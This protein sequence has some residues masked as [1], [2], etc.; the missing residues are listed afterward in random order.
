[1]VKC[2][3]FSLDEMKKGF[4]YDSKRKTREREGGKEWTGEEIEL[5]LLCK[6]RRFV[7]SGKTFCDLIQGWAKL[8]RA[9]S[10]R[11]TNSSAM[12]CVFRWLCLILTR[13]PIS[14]RKLSSTKPG[15]QE[16]AFEYKAHNI[17]KSTFPDCN[18]SVPFISLKCLPPANETYL[19]P[20][21]FLALAHFYSAAMF[22]SFCAR[23][24]FRHH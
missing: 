2:H 23:L 7:V 19:F 16:E 3:N 18:S 10:R 24:P 20:I 14:M 5:N 12:R 6:A 1:M 17:F 22:F 4:H 11:F 9:A 21:S 13:L 8:P 15:E